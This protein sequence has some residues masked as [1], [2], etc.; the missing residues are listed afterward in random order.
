LRADTARWTGASSLHASDPCSSFRSGIPKR[1]TERI[2]SS[3]AA[4][5]SSTRVS[6]EKWKFPGMAEISV[7]TPCPERT[8]SG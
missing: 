8:K 7:F 3:R 2:P 5:T 1:I 6:T 4:P